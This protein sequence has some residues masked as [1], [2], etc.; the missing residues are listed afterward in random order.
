MNE[1][2]LTL[3][4]TLSILLQAATAVIAVCM[5]KT[6]GYFKPWMFIASAVTL[7]TIRRIVSLC[8]L[9]RPEVSPAAGALESELVALS[10][11]VLMLIG[12]IQFRPIFIA[13][14]QKQNQHQQNLERREAL[15]K[16]SNHRIKNNLMLLTSLINLKQ[17]APE[18]KSDF[19][20]ISKQ[21]DTIR[22]IHEKLYRTESFES[23]KINEY[24]EE[25]ITSLLKTLSHKKVTVHTDIEDIELPPDTALT[26]GLLINEIATNA[27]KYGFSTEEPPVFSVELKQLQQN[28]HLQVHN[29]GAPFPDSVDFS[30][31]QTLGLKIMRV[32]ASQLNGTIAL[33][34]RPFPVFEITF[35]HNI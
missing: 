6:S 8:N 2:V 24:L 17:P 29:T 1:T 3:I 18:N 9:L 4:L 34:K 13:I 21:I 12:M 35:P 14:R 28:Y 25:I 10:I 23:V 30:N 19:D 16:E 7:M 5:I 26:L 22:I 27:I 15:L 31:P 33:Q 20:E 32:L 11:S